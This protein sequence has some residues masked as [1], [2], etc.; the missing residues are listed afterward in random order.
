MYI[1]LYKNLGYIVQ[2]NAVDAKVNLH[3]DEGTNLLGL[4]IAEKHH[5][6]N[7]TFG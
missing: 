7:Q 2:I 1:L 5:I 4:N 6:L 3:Y